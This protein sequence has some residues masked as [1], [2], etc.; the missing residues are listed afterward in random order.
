MFL[1]TLGSI[2]LSEVHLNSSLTTVIVFSGGIH[3]HMTVTP[4]R[5]RKIRLT[6]KEESKE[7][8]PDL[9]SISLLGILKPAPSSSL[10][11]Y[12]SKP[13]HK[14]PTSFWT[15]A[16]LYHDVHSLSLTSTGQWD[17]YQ[18]TMDKE[19]NIFPFI[20]A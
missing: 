7:N 10:P 2:I 13:F 9:T 15:A 20:M 17:F 18:E 11:K 12:D 6:K 14:I 16:W 3:R 4:F 8:K 1:K 19:D 5:E